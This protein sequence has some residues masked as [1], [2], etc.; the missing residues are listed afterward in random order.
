M[1]GKQLF[2]NMLYHLYEANAHNQ[3]IKY[4][5]E[6]GLDDRAREEEKTRDRHIREG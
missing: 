1:S 5:K 4:L 6:M 2:E 3:S